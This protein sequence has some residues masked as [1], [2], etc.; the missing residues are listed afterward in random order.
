VLDLSGLRKDS[1]SQVNL[2]GSWVAQLSSKSVGITDL[3]AVAANGTHRF[4]GADI[5][6][7]HLQLRA[8]DRFSGTQILL[9]KGT[10]FGQRSTFHGK[11]LWVT[12]AVGSFYDE[13]SVND[14]CKTAYPNKSG[15]ALLNV[16][17]ARRLTSPH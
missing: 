3:S 14:F 9:L 13:Q 2:D 4:L 15:G 12:L 11:A 7:E 8:D 10:D 1:L 5:L 17:T 6:K 16:C